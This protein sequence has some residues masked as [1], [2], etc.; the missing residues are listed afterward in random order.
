MCF[1]CTIAFSQH[2]VSGYVRDMDE[3]RPLHSTSVVI[4]GTN[5]GTSTDTS[6]FFKVN[7]K[8]GVTLVFSYLGYISQEVVVGNDTVLNIYLTK[9][10]GKLD[11]VVVTGY[12]SQRVKEI[13]GAVSVISAADINSAPDGQMDKILQGKAAGLTVIS[14]GE[15]GAPSNIRINGIGNF[16]DV[17]PLYVIDG[18]QGDINSLNPNDIESIQVLKDAGSYSIYGVRGANGVIVITTK[19]GKSGKTT[20]NFDYYNNVQEPLSKGLDLLDPQGQ[21]DLIWLALRNSGQVDPNTGNPTSTLY[22]NGPTPVLP[23]YFVGVNGYPAGD[24]TVNPSTYNVTPGSPIHQIVKF[25]KQGTDWFHEL[26]KPAWSQNYAFSAAGGNDKNHYLFSLGYLDQQGTFLETYLK[27]FTTR[28]NTD[29]NV[30]NAIR[31]GENLQL[32]QSQSP[33]NGGDISAAFFTDPY[34]PVYDI[35]G[36]YSSEGGASAGPA[37]NPVGG[38][39]LTKND[40]NNNWQVFGNVFGEVDILKHLTLRSSFGGTFNFYNFYNYT[41]GPY[42]PTEGLN[43]FAENTGYSSSWTWTNTLSYSKIFA[44]KH[45]IK[46]LVGTENVSD[47]TRGQGG[48]SKG[49]FSDNPNYRLLGNGDGIPSDQIVFSAATSA[50]LSSF[51]SRAEYGYDEKIFFTATLRQDGSSVFGPGNRFGWFPSVSAAWRITQEN[52]MKNISW[53]SDLKL[54]ASWGTSGFNGNTNPLNQYTLYGSSSG[55]T[56][57]DIFGTGNSVVKGFTVVQYGNAKTGWQKDIVTNA[58]LEAILWEGKLSINADWYE[59]KSTGLLFAVSLPSLLGYAAPPNVNVGEVDN[60]GVNITIGSK[61]KFLKDWGWNGSLAITTYKS[62]VVKLNDV[63]YFDDAF[64]MGAIGPVVRN[65]VGYP[66]G[67]FFG[68]KIVGIFQS[69]AEVDNSPAQD[70]KAVGTFRY[71][72]ANHDG[73]INDQDRVHFG[74]PNPIFTAGINIGFTYKNFDLST[75]SYWSYGNDVMNELS[76]NSDIF[77]GLYFSPKSKAALY[78]SWTPQNPSASIPKV[79]VGQNF[80]T[81]GAV[82]S[83]PLEKGS[84]FRNKTMILGY[85]LPA[86]FLQRL[87]VSRLR[88]YVEVTNLFTIT[89]YRGLDPELPGT[90]SAYGIDTGH[91]PDNQRQFLIGLNMGF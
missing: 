7:A 55:G 24:P 8:K 29:F 52:F 67:S 81:D 91:Y 19:K 82:N 31:F 49:Y 21:A 75:F 37:N 16:G 84:Y 41:Y 89:K 76:I 79:L 5:L 32:T 51:I 17:T 15:P 86:I 23:D 62:K 13:T 58:G 64:I 22:G 30:N 85:T 33:Q 25:N 69:Q 59:K 78:D 60:N 77:G 6:G 90:S 83:Y 70:G 54:R 2:K 28:I 9:S 68:Y 88:A 71:L 73:V 87:K 80:S 39:T 63:P 42:D 53:L 66:L 43:S 44:K 11:Q 56:F 65:E 3:R 38:R 34:L 72:D 36:N 48:T 45:S 61:G 18:V 74:N 1:K 35:A 47:Y 57:Y 50:F 26:F 27:K 14:S 20:M 4:K 10:L 40:V 12:T 46:L